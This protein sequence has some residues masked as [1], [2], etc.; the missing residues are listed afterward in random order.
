MKTIRLADPSLNFYDDY[1]MCCIVWYLG[2]P[3][4]LL[5][6]INVDFSS[7]LSTKKNIIQMMV[8]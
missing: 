3:F 5:E 1:A 8:P 4:I 7:F 2:Y 6:S